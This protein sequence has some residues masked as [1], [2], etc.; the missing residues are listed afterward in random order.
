[1]HWPSVFYIFGSLGVLWYFVWER[2]AE[3]SPQEDANISA[4]ER[5]YIY[6]HTV[7]RVVFCTLWVLAQSSCLE[8]S[9][10]F[11]QRPCPLLKGWLF[12]LICAGV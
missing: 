2:K 10:I 6:A 5:N 11:V 1:M 9:S 7:T 12:A 3:S 8:C 4:E